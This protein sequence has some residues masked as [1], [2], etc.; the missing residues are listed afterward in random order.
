MICLDGLHE[1]VSKWV[2]GFIEIIIDVNHSIIHHWVVLIRI[3]SH[4]HCLCGEVSL[5]LISI[6]DVCLFGFWRYRKDVNVMSMQ[7]FFFFYATNCIMS[8]EE[9][10]NDL[11]LLLF[12]GK[13]KMSGLIFSSFSCYVQSWLK[14]TKC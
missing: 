7:M 12:T 3:S 2:V 14:S 4:S 8:T 11:N 13:F 10:Q 1:S 6:D 5:D 9:M